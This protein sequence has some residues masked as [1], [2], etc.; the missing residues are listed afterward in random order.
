M[1]KI[2]KKIGW[3][4]KENIG[5]SSREAKRLNCSLTPQLTPDS[6]NFC[7]SNAIISK[8]KRVQ[9]SWARIQRTLELG[10]NWIR[11]E[12]RAKIDVNPPPTLPPLYE[13]LKK[14]INSILVKI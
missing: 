2:K 9:C 1:V 12:L 6:G 5:I 14:R 7:N 3:N 8:F 4:R 10:L 11:E 13:Y